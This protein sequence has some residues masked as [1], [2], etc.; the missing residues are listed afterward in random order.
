MKMKI[1]LEGLAEVSVIGCPDECAELLALW[2]KHLLDKQQKDIKLDVK[3]PQC[4]DGSWHSCVAAALAGNPQAVIGKMYYVTDLIDA[5][6]TSDSVL[7]FVRKCN[8][9]NS[10]GRPMFGTEGTPDGKILT[11]KYWREVK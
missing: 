10:Y 5:V 6:G 4:D 9:F 1:V 8:G 3:Q 11:W 2:E 7:G